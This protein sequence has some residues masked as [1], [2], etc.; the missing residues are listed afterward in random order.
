[1]EVHGFYIVIILFIIILVMTIFAYFT[2]I[3]LNVMPRFQPGSEGNYIVDGNYTIA[4]NIYVAWYNTVNV[5]LVVATLVALTIDVV[6]SYYAPN[7]GQGIF[8]IFSMFVVVPLWLVLKSPLIQIGQSFV[9]SPTSVTLQTQPT[10]FNFYISTY[11]ILIVCSFICLSA[12]MNF[13][14]TNQQ[15]SGGG[16][17]GFDDTRSN[18]ETRAEY[19]SNTT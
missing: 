1:M 9:S 16:Y 19:N 4:Q 12:I 2:N 6:I 14:Q 15:S 3:F 10:A 13:R 11:F 8:N 5:G 7:A 18:S 17:G